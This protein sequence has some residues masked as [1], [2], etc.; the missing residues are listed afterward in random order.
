MRFLGFALLAIAAPVAVAQSILTYAGGGTRDGLQAKAIVLTAPYGLAADGKGNLYIAE[1]SGSSVQ[2][3]NLATGVIERFAGN[4]GRRTSR[5]A[6]TRAAT[7]A[8]T[9]P[10]AR[11][12]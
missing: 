12:P 6:A 8:T 5:S 10:R 3:V 4:G 9:G 2:R 7:A 11:H 1:E